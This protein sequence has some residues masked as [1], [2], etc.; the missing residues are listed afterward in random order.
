MICGKL[1]G[2]SIK[3]WIIICCWRE[4]AQQTRLAHVFDLIIWRREV[5]FWVVLVAYRCTKTPTIMGRED[6][7][8]RWELFSL[9]PLKFCLFW[10]YSESLYAETSKPAQHWPSSWLCELTSPGVNKPG[11][12][13]SDIYWQSLQAQ[14]AILATPIYKYRLSLLH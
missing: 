8:W 6:K 13:T 4:V 11:V 1:F 2:K 5:E 14:A 10:H 7:P 12:D 3:T 9:S